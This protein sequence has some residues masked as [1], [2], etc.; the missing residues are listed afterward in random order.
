MIALSIVL[1]HEKA[2]E[3]V[4]GMAAT[5]ELANVCDSSRGQRD[6]VTPQR[7]DRSIA[8]RNLK[9]TRGLRVRACQMPGSLDGGIVNELHIQSWVVLD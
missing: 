1:A 8:A 4:C 5:P 9:Y 2:G 6:S 3:R 7:G